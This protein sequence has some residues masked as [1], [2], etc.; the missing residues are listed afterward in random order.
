M[1][2]LPDPDPPAM[3]RTNMP[4]SYRPT[5]DPRKPVRAG[6]AADR[7]GPGTGGRRPDDPL[8]VVGGEPGGDEV[9]LELGLGL[10][11]PDP[12]PVRG[13][14]QGQGDDHPRGDPGDDGD[15]AEE[16]VAVELAEGFF[17]REGSRGWRRR[18]AAVREWPAPVFARWGQPFDPGRELTR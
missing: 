2:D 14:D 12:P 18:R 17:H 16:L 13:D 7:P 9:P 15:E 1:V 5:S 11:L 10:R 6:A 3:P 8:D 4:A